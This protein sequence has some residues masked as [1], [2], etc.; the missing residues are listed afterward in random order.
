MLQGYSMFAIS[1]AFCHILSPPAA[2]CAGSYS[3]QKIILTFA[4]SPVARSVSSF[5]LKASLYALS[6]AS[7]PS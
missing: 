3:D 2:F 6:Y 4:I 7:I 5:F 1:P